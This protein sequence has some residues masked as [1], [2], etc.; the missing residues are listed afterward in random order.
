MHK[1]TFSLTVRTPLHRCVTAGV[2]TPFAKKA[3]PA[4]MKKSVKKSAVKA[5]VCGGG[6]QLEGRGLL[7]VRGKARSID[8]PTDA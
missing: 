8:R 3:A 2:A 5:K 4:S 1:Q 6:P 7:V